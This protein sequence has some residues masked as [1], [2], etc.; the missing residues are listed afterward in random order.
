[1]G[2]TKHIDSSHKLAPVVERYA[3]K[4][5]GFEMESVVWLGSREGNREEPAKVLGVEGE[6]EEGSGVKENPNGRWT[7]LA[8]GR[9]GE[10]GTSACHK[11]AL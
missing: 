9:V 2:E 7:A 1:M 6:E 3:D 8:E 10:D 5:E 11:E 4:T